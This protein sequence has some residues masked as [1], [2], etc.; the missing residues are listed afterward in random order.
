MSIQSKFLL[1]YSV[2]LLIPIMIFILFTTTVINRYYE[3][4][5]IKRNQHNLN[6]I[7]TILE[8]EII[9]INSI[10]EQ[11]IQDNM[12]KSYK[13]KDNSANFINIEI[14]MRKYTSNNS[15][16]DTAYFSSNSTGYIYGVDTFTI[17]RYCND[18]IKNEFF[19][20]IDYINLFT[21]TCSAKWI[22]MSDLTIYG[23]KRRFTTCVIPI[24]KSF[25]GNKATRST[26]IFHINYN[27][28]SEIVKPLLLDSEFKIIINIGDSIIY[29]NDPTFLSNNSNFNDY[30]SL[31]SLKQSRGEEFSIKLY[32]S[33][34][35]INKITY[36][37]KIISLGSLVVSLLLGVIG[38]LFAMKFNYLPIKR[39]STFASNLF[40][41]NG[42]D[43]GELD[44]TRFILERLV[45]QNKNITNINK[46]YICERTVL[47]LISNTTS[48]REQVAEECN[49]SGINTNS[50]YYISICLDIYNKEI[51]ESIGLKLQKIEDLYYAELYESNNII[52]VVGSK[53]DDFIYVENLLKSIGLDKI[54]KSTITVGVGDFVENIE[55]INRS[56]C[57]ALISLQN[58]RTKNKTISFYNKLKVKRYKKS[59]YDRTNIENLSRAISEMDAKSIRRKSHI[60]KDVLRSHP[61]D[62]YIWIYII[63]D[64]VN[65]SIQ[66][67]TELDINCDNLFNKYSYLIHNSNFDSILNVENIIDK[68]VSDIL[69][70]IEKEKKV[71]N[72]SKK[73]SLNRD[74][75]VNYINR[76]YKTNNFS[77][78][79]IANEF[80]TSLSNVS[81]FFKTHFDKNIS[82]YINEIRIN[83]A[84]NLLLN[85]GMTISDIVS[86][87][88]GYHP[89]SFIRSF[90]K[91]EG[92]TPGEYRANNRP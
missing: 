85:S 84:K 16:I 46:Q 60:F 24:E 3:S 41:Y 43:S 38:I 61:S 81:H 13:F 11:I 67:L 89:S 86:E 40:Q 8:S 54:E 68:I 42:K 71:N 91:S 80:N 12:F 87:I 76:N 70:I 92:L 34:D 77:V 49:L 51:K 18:V 66:A 65:T 4:E 48:N 9:N 29:Y 63:H 50:N 2:I 78:K 53:F 64:I 1:S 6:N 32:L 62:E 22:P 82:T 33:N 37:L 74:E 27:A 73:S 56:Y 90:K 36:P 88:G 72:N 21:S 20:N 39:L 17:D 23:E 7:H 83:E 75:I 58:S 52:L 15:F 14:T 10:T 69:S 28:I 79:L 47:K 30:I 59:L 57:Q 31:N 35:Y 26:V 5:I 45:E 25:T 19:K 55:K 44:T